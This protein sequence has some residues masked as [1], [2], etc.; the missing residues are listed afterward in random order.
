MCRQ[1]VPILALDLSGTTS[2]SLLARI[3]WINAHP[4]FFCA[5][6]ALAVSYGGGQTGFPLLSFATLFMERAVDSFQLAV[7]SLQ[8]KVVIDRAFWRQVL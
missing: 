1:N 4:A 3:V 5:F 8:I 2:L 6:H 7:I